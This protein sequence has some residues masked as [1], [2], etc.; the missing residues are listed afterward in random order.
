MDK[1]EINNKIILKQKEVDLEQDFN[2]KNQLRS[3]LQIL[4]LR[5]DILD[6]KEKIDKLM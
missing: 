4:N 5:K 1:N 6:T 3:E 2:K